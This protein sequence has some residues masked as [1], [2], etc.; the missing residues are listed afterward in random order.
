MGLLGCLFS[1]YLGFIPPSQLKTGNH[2]VYVL[3]LVAAVVALSLPPF[4][5]QGWQRISGG[6]PQVVAAP[7]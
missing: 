1:F 7:A 2:A 3:M 6:R 5:Y 4:L